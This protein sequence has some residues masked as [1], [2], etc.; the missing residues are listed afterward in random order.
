MTA[1]LEIYSD[2]PE[3]MAAKWLSKWGNDVALL[4]ALREA[5]G[6]GYL[7]MPP[8]YVNQ[9]LETARKAD[10][11]VQRPGKAETKKGS[12]AIQPKSSEARRAALR[13]VGREPATQGGE[14]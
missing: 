1:V 11:H 10:G 8:P 4:A 7:S 9:V 2:V 3:G 13:K 5:E 6:F 14:P 12:G